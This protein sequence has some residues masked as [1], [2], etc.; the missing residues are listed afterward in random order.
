MGCVY[1][2]ELDEVHYIR[3]GRVSKV[4]FGNKSVPSV[5]DISIHSEETITASGTDSSGTAT[6]VWYGRV[7][8]DKVA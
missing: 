6:S 5:T 2:A 4:L 1:F 7:S 3:G 8:E